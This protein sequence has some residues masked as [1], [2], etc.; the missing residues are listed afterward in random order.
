MIYKIYDNNG[1]FTHRDGHEKPEL[2]VTT[3]DHR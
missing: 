1:R 3:D 2:I